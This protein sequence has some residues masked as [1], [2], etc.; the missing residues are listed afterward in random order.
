MPGDQ[1]EQGRIDLLSVLMHEVGHVL[2]RD[3]GEEGVMQESLG[4]GERMELS[5]VYVDGPGAFLPLP[6]PGE[7]ELSA[8]GMTRRR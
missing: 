3:H 6:L 4:T 5:G 1:G 8:V 2:G 7:G